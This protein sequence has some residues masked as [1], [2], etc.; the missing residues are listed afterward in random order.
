MAL[1]LPPEV[2]QRWSEISPLSA[3]ETFTQRRVQR[4]KAFRPEEC[5]LRTVSADGA[6]TH[7]SEFLSIDETVVVM[8]FGLVLPVPFLTVVV[9]CCVLRMFDVEL[10]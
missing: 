8:C 10:A 2:D 7:G 3:S 1:I 4:I 5:R 6:K 9:S